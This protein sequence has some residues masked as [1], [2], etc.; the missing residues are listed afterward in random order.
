M[1]ES[2][3]IE[4][5][6]KKAPRNKWLIINTA[7]IL[8][9]ASLAGILA[10]QYWAIEDVPEPPLQVSFLTAA[11][12]PPPPPPPPPPAAPKPVAPK[13]VPVPQAPVEIAQPVVVPDIIPEAPSEPVSE[14]VEGVEG[15]EG[16]VEGG[17]AGGVVGGTPNSVGDE[18]LRVGGEI[19][20]PE[21]L[22]GGSP[23]YTELARK[24][25]IQGVVIVEAIIDKEGKVTNVRVLKGL[26]M[27]LDQAAVDAVK[28]WRFRPATL[29]GRPV[30]VYYSLTVNFRLQ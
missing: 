23:S 24:A 2:A 4:S 18:I 30:S 20:K 29:N 6:K 25:R 21:R 28:S 3:L 16:G 7:I 11:A 12:P 9:V 1:F 5:Q 19:T 17:V 8:H 10:A 13:P 22:S 26:P 14:G 15:V 27:G